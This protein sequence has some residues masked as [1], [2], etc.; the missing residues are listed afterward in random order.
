M[1]NSRLRNSGRVTFESVIN[2]HCKRREIAVEEAMMESPKKRRRLVRLLKDLRKR[3]MIVIL[4][5]M[6]ILQNGQK[7][8]MIGI[9][10]RV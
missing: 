1:S 3:M 2:E 4:M 9:L 6:V 5:I 7:I 8:L 10:L